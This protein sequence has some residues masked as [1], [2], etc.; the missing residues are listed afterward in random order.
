MTN[1]APARQGAWLALFMMAGSLVAVAGPNKA[2]AQV[3]PARTVTVVGYRLNL[4]GRA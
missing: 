3:W 1:Y 4:W 2:L